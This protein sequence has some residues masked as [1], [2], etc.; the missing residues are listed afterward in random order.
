M[1]DA[2]TRKLLNDV[3]KLLVIVVQQN[4]QILKHLNKDQKE[5]E[6]VIVGGSDKC[7]KCNEENI[8]FVNDDM[9]KC[10]C[11]ACGA[12]WPCQ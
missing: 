2:S 1:M 8:Y 12:I 7:P 5:V 6:E 9:T 3:R 4:E 10:K 11:Q